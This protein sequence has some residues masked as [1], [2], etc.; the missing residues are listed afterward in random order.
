MLKSWWAGNYVSDWWEQYVYLRNRDPL[1]INS[2]FYC[3]DN[4][5][6]KTKIQTA[7]AAN[8]TKVLL[9]FREKVDN[10]SL[11]PIMAQ[12]IVPLCSWQYKR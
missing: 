7:R 10:E 12:G 9:G 11:P 3:S 1:M 5:G 4:I 8:I 6:L 2:N